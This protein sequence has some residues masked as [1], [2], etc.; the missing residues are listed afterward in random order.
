MFPCP[1]HIFSTAVSGLF[2]FVFFPLDCFS[3]SGFPVTDTRCA[4]DE[5]CRNTRRGEAEKSSSFCAY[6]ILGWVSFL[7]T[8]TTL[9][10]VTI[11]GGHSM[12]K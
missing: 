11:H 12:L 8:F 3:A 1:A 5:Q 10:V 7:G 2:E 4:G 6:V 9:N